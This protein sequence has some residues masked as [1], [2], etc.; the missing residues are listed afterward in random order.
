MNKP[1]ITRYEDMET[2]MT[3]YKIYMPAVWFVTRQKYK[4][5]ILWLVFRSM[6]FTK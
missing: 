1:K 6:F 4:F 2:M 3:V 5:Q